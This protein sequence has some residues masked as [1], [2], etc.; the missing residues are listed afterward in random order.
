MRN[1]PVTEAQKVFRT[2]SRPQDIVSP[3]KIRLGQGR[4]AINRSEGNVSQC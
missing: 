4:F 2:Q 1:V 3:Y